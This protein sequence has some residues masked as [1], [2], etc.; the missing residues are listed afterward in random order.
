MNTSLSRT[1]F[2]SKKVMIADKIVCALVLLSLGISGLRADLMMATVYFLLYP[3]LLLTLRSP[4]I[5]HLLASSLVAS[6]WYLIAKEQY[7]YNREML[8]IGGHTVYPLF[9]W[10]VGLFGVY[11]MYAYW[12][13]LLPF[14][15]IPVRILFF[16]MLYWALLFG[17]EILAYNYFQFRNIATAGYAG[18]PLVDC[19]HVP[20][21]MQVAYLVNGPIYFL[22]CELSG[23]PDP[24]LQMRPEPAR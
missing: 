23:F 10:A 17:S 15:S 5:K 9:A 20:V 4:A 3:Y 2:F 6:C 12:V 16:A 7:G 19:I 13:R 14:R 18:L 24:S 21:W 8:L 22:I 11:L 1:P